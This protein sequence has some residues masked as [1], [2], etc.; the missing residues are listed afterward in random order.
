[1]QVHMVITLVDFPCPEGHVVKAVLGNDGEEDVVV[2][3]LVRNGVPGA[4]M[5]SEEA[6]RRL[7]RMGNKSSVDRVLAFAQQLD[8]SPSALMQALDSTLDAMVL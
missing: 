5:R 3:A 2:F 7:L 6:T 8:T 4:V 1:M